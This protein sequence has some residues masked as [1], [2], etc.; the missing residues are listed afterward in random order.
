MDLGSVC[1]INFNGVDYYMPDDVQSDFED[2]M[3]L[4]E[5]ALAATSG[6]SES[7]APPVGVANPTC[8]KE[9]EGPHEQVHEQGVVCTAS[10]G[11]LM[12]SCYSLV[13]AAGQCAKVRPHPPLSLSLS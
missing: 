8:A 13:L 10:P 7:I 4:T 1:V 9:I 2:Y 5:A 12:L 6:V 11:H 3:H